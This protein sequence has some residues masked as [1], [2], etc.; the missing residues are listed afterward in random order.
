M[1]NSPLLPRIRSWLRSLFRRSRAESEMD[2]E[3]RF[4][5]E[6]RA[7]DLMR[8]GVP[9]AEALRRA[10]LEFGAL[11]S[12]K[13]E[14]REAVGIHF[15]ETLAQDVRYGL[16]SLRKSPG[17]AAVAILTLALGI[18]AN[19]AI[20][21]VVNTALL[22]PLA[23]S[24]PGRLYL[25]RE[26]VPQLARFDPLVDVNLPD[27]EIWR[28]KV[29]SFSDV[30]IAEP[31]SADLTGLGEPEVIHGVRASANILS[32]LGIEPALGRSFLPEEDEPGRG[33]VVILA[34][35]FWRAR[36]HADP[37]VLGKTLVLDGIPHQIV[38]VLPSSFRFP[39][40]MGGVSSSHSLDFF[41]PLDGP[42]SYER[43]LIGEF[44]FTGIA[45]L[46][47]GVS[48]EQ[49]L[50]ELNLVQAQIAK[51]AAAGD[52]LAAALQPLDS[53]VIGPA[54][55]GLIF[56]LAAVGAVLLIVCANLACLLLAR[57]PSRMREAAIR[58]ALGASRRRIFRQMLTETFLFSIAGGALG[59]WVAHL[60]VDALAHS[61]AAGIPRLDEVAID[62]RVLLFALAVTLFTAVLFGIL[63]AR[64]LAH[65]QPLDVLKSASTTASESRKTR[66]LRES[67]VG[68]EVGL[69]TSL[70]I[71]A[72]LLV[73]SLLHLLSV[74]AGFAV[75]RVLVASIDLPPQSYAELSVR[76]SFYD[77]S[78]DALKSLPGVRA[79]GWVSIPPLAGDG[80]ITGITIP[81][82]SN[83]ETPV[84]SYRPVSPDYFSA[85]GIP[86][87][88]GRGFTPADA[89]RK[90]VVVSQSVAARFW[91]GENPI[92]QT[93]IAQWAGDVPSEVIGVVAD[94]RT[95]RLDRAPRM[96]VYVPSWFNSISVPSSG[97]FVLRTSGDPRD[98]ASAVRALIHKID[99]EVP[100]ISVRAMSQVVSESVTAR[101]FQMLLV[102]LFGLSSLLLAALGI[103]GVTGYSVEQRR[104]ELGIRIA[105]GADSRGI[106]GIVLRQ[107]MAPV[108]L[109][110]AAGLIVAA[111]AGRLIAALLFGVAPFD[112][113]TFV[114]ASTILVGA[115]L[116]ACYIPARR[117]MRVDPISALRCE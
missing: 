116:L 20:F 12:A 1:N 38:G 105:L 4:H 51:Q 48:P 67:L 64:R 36:F 55:R 72:G 37:A 58:T 39:R 63:P 31:T 44:D 19:T 13:E 110:L 117:A 21:S 5:I 92:G 59:V 98:S 42:K 91:P 113:I 96:M 43:D 85:M 86:V 74:N 52:G 101:R 81:G 11:D 53:E 106:L 57:V 16:R 18:G 68:V 71:L 78:L 41:R 35:G 10:R 80:S 114:G 54:R 104:R 87:L 99:P 90:V 22:R 25:V 70:L 15:L 6:A 46:K 95:V 102:L 24:D 77:R 47:P 83:T 28:Q 56:L 2:S 30:A 111:L 112:P 9:A 93:C 62:A 69:T 7:D 33:R 14:C 32:V 40:A 66:R 61:P 97:S 79:V 103:F 115:A 88:Q 107:G 49:A 73:S 84:A 3:L 17:F 82:A 23:Y 8:A 100:V 89:G 27:F 26:I 65:L 108:L 45:R 109:G 60:A 29:R 75:E 50:A 94:V 76:L 34:D